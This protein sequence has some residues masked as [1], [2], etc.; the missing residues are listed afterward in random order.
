MERRWLCAIA[1]CAALMA[2]VG[3]TSSSSPKGTTSSPPVSS[4][5]ADPVAQYLAAVNKLCD[6]L[7]PKV[8]AVTNGGSLDIPLDAFLA[9]LPAHT[10]LRDG[11]DRDLA[12]IPVPAGAEAKARALAAYIAYA[13]ELDVKRLRAA[14][15]GK[16][17]YEREINAESTSA[18]DDPTIA[19]RTAAGFH[20]S[21]NAR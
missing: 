3:C 2:L 14:R 17:S 15:Q 7:L 20:D 18:A 11:F 16:A 9:Q 10:R 4:S 8:I 12:R 21:C 1:A 19:A 6:D 13:N 5:T